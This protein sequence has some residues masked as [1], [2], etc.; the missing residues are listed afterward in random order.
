MTM[1]LL[2]A[3]VGAIAT[4]AWLCVWADRIESE[5]HNKKGE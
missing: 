4:L 3:M 1:F 2:G 5:K